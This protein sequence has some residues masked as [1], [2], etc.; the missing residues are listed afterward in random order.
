MRDRDE[1]DRNRCGTPMQAS[2]E[3]ALPAGS[4]FLLDTAT[5]RQNPEMYR[6]EPDYSPSLERANR[7]PLS[8][9]G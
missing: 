1:R 7:T 8:S 9:Y 2:R 6:Y 5:S 4:A 3:T